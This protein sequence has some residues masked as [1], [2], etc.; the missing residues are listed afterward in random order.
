[1]RFVVRDTGVGIPGPVLEQLFNPF[2][3]ADA[4]TTRRH[5]GTGLGLSIAKGLV[6]AMGGTTRRREH[7]GNR[8]QILVHPAAVA[9][10]MHVSRMNSTGSSWAT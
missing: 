5:G 6:E 9:R 8:I 10:V 2:V 1:M 3:Q 4:S 7:G